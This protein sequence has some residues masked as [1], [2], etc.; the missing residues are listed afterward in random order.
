MSS[1]KISR[2]EARA[3]FR[4]QRRD[5]RVD[6]QVA[7]AA[8]VQMEVVDAGDVVAGRVRGDFAGQVA[9]QH[10]RELRPQ[11]FAAR[12]FEQVFQLRIPGFDAVFEVDG[13]HAD[14]QRF[15][16]I[17]AEILQPLDLQRPFVRAIDRA[18]RFRSRWPHS[19]RWWKAVPGRRLKGNRRP[20]SCPGRARRRCGRGSGRR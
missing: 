16:D 20:P 5:R 12:N 9:R 3:V 19:R 8:R 15:D 1:S 7:A 11:R 6:H 17:F 10:V 14:A 13:Q 18:G 4:Q 2:P